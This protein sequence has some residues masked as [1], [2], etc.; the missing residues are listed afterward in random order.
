MAS[1]DDFTTSHF[2]LVVVGSGPNGAVAVREFRA[3]HPTASILMLE[4]GSPISARR[5]EHLVEVD[6]AGM[7]NS[8][9]R[10]MRMAR[11]QAYVQGA[12]GERGTSAQEWTVADVGIAPAMHLGNDMREFPGAA[13]SWNVGGMGVH[14]TAACPWP[15]GGE[16]PPDDGTGSW[17]ADLALGCQLLRVDASGYAG[18]PFS[19]PIIAA[20]QRALPVTDPTRAAQAMPMAGPTDSAGRLH[21]TGPLDILPILD[22][23]SD[24]AFT[25]RTGALCTRVVQS[26]GQVRGVVVRDIQTGVETEYGAGAVL[27]AADALRTPQLLWASGI[28]PAALGLRL[29]EHASID[30][31]VQVDAAR[32]GDAGLS[33]LV[34]P[35]GEPFV[36]AYWVPSNGPD[37]PA[38]GQIMETIDEHEGHHLRMGWY[39]AT[40]VRPENRLEF[41]DTESDLLGMPR[42]TAHFGYSDA[43][44]EGIQ[45]ARVIQ[46]RAVASIGDIEEPTGTLWPAGASLH[47]TGTVRM[48]A[49]DDGTSVCD[50]QGAV[51]GVQ[52][53]YVAGNGVIPT[54]LTCNSTLTSVALTVRTA[55]A[56][57]DRIRV[58]V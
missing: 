37:Q 21:R 3:A 26:G 7:R 54:A 44:L 47:Y 30:G 40:Q 52:G 13:M 24:P 19:G 12:V 10:L 41:S 11:Q 32:L 5:G 36:G 14:W 45:L 8:A 6:A 58:T 9:Q 38:H 33:L 34:H 28:R 46:A 16:V 20:L 27:I 31:R 2:D 1:D 43:D 17:E 29:N 57:A 39:V 4:G 49:T 56:V 55:R 23:G 51:W 35:T 25:L 22:D 15:Y 50:L 48:G 42:I 18:N 53:V